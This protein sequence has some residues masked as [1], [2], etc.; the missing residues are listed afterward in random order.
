VKYR[1]VYEYDFGDSWEHELVVEQVLP[2]EPG[3]TVPICLTGKRACPPEDVGGIWSYADFL[4]ALRDP[5]HAEH[6]EYTEWIGGEFDPEA[7]DNEA[8][9]REL[10]RH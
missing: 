9:N 2:P 6:E 8:V 10:Q 3:A 5:E 7:F 1:F 4:E